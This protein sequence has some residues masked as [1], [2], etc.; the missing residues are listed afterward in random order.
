MK[1][2]KLMLTNNGDIELSNGSPMY[3]SKL[4]QKINNWAG[5]IITIPSKPISFMPGFV[6]SI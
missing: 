1:T 5:E 2:Y 4:E 3:P 6:N